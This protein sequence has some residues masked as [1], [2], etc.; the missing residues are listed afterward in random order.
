MSHHSLNTLD[1]RMVR[2]LQLIHS[3]TWSSHSVLWLD[4]SEGWSPVLN[5]F[6]SLLYSVFNLLEGS[7]FLWFWTPVWR[8]DRGSWLWGRDNCSDS[9]MCVSPPLIW[10]DR[11]LQYLTVGVGG[12]HQAV[13]SEQYRMILTDGASYLFWSVVAQY[14]APS[15]ERVTPYISP[16]SLDCVINVQTNRNTSN[17]LFVL[18]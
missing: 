9:F 6:I 8:P 13:M 18:V 16:H 7:L 12:V 17:P 4:L 11:V 15:L 5:F 10:V 14:N 1:I 3:Y 2:V